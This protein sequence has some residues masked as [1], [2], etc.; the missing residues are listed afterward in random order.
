MTDFEDHLWSHLSA[1]EPTASRRLDRT[2]R[3]GANDRWCWAAA[4][5][6]SPP[7]PWAWCSR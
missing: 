1:T 7:S 2:Q 5:P 3:G 4:P 6:R